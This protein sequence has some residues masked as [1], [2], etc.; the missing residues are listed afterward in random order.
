MVMICNWEVG[1]RVEG[2]CEEPLQVSG[3]V[4]AVCSAHPK[5]GCDPSWEPGSLGWN[6]IGQPTD[7]DMWYRVNECDIDVWASRLMAKMVSQC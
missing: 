5:W 3:V 6:L 2:V 7:G 1:R 4:R